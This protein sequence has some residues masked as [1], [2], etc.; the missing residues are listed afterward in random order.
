MVVRRRRRRRP[1]RKIILGAGVLNALSA[2][3]SVGKGATLGMAKA[4]GHGAVKLG[5]KA[6]KGAA[7]GAATSGAAY[8]V[9]KLLKKKRRKKRRA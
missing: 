2:L 5:T 6:V 9:R 4:L 8:G 3:G 1:R 7:L